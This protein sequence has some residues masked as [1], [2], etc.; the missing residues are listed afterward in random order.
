MRPDDDRQHRQHE[1]TPIVPQLEYA[2]HRDPRPPMYAIVLSILA[3]G[4]LVGFGT[5]CLFG[6]IAAGV[7]MAR[8]GSMPQR[9]AFI[10]FAIL[11]PMASVFLVAGITQIMG[12]IRQLRGTTARDTIVERGFGLLNRPF[13]SG[14]IRYK[15][16]RL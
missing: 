9:A 1:P 16:E 3:S 4:F 6:C 5:L 11:F 7:S 13:F 10:M 15:R 14:R 8:G 12:T 2:Q